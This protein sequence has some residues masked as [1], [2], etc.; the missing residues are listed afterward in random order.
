MEVREP[1][2]VPN[3]A[4]MDLIIRNALNETTTGLGLSGEL[5]GL[6][7]FRGAEYIHVLTEKPIQSV[8]WMPGN[9]KGPK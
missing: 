8:G 6:H 3:A 4:V 7:D 5:L 2:P 1:D 9:L